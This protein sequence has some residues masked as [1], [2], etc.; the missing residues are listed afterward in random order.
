LH[1]R[2]KEIFLAFGDSQRAITIPEDSI[3]DLVAGKQVAAIADI[4]SAARVALHSPI[5]SPPLSVVVKPGDK[6]VIVASDMTR[7]WI[8]YDLFLP[9]LLD[10]LNAAGIPD[11]DITLVVALGA[12]RRHTAAENTLTYGPDV[13]QRIRIVQ[14]YALEA[15]HFVSLGKTSRGVEIKINRY[16]AAADKVILTGGISYHSMAGFSGGRKALLPG[17]SAYD[18]IQSNHRLCLHSEPGKGLNPNCASGSL[19]DNEMHQDMMEIAQAINPDFL[20]NAVYTPE[21]GFAAFVAG[22]WQE[23]WQEGCEIVRKMYEAPLSGKADLVITSAGGF[24]NDINFYQASK[25]VENASMAVRDGGVLIAAMECRDIE[26]P[27][28]FSQWFDLQSLY[29]RETV[30]RENFTVPGFVALKSGLIAREFSVII[31][32][33]PQNR[34]F[35]EKAGMIV[36][37]NME[38]A[39]ELSRKIL[40]TPNPKTTILLYGAN[41]L[42][43]FKK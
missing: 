37:D 13:V 43:V 38:E 35:L 22:H 1:S 20:L 18:S 23:A 15:E 40:G 21:G 36:A 39:L 24:P 6:I 7:M 10:E 30:L 32:S 5:G 2:Y 14:S 4:P 41:T 27:P 8:R 9:T 16:V 33:L 31:V 26:D 11:C 28:D 42:P 3:V 12:H 29:D 25:A 34:D 19:L 17:V